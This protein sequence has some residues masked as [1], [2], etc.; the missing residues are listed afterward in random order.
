[1]V[2]CVTVRSAPLRMWRIGPRG[3]SINVNSFGAVVHHCIMAFDRRVG[4]CRL[5]RTL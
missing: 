3:L 1:M 2:G 5:L 4:I